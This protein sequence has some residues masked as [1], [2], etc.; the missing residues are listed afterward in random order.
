MPTFATSRLAHLGVPAAFHAGLTARRAPRFHILLHLTI[1]LASIASAVAAIATWSR[2]VAASANEAAK[3][4][5]ALLY[6]NDVGA[7]KE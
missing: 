2:Y 3:A 7:A 4:A 6:D 5:H 1:I